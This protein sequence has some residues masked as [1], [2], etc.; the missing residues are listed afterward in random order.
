MRGSQLSV[1][2]SQLVKYFLFFAFLALTPNL[3]A[4]STPDRL[5]TFKSVGDAEL[6]LH[7]FNPKGHKAGDKRPVIVFFFGGGWVGGTPA[8]F[9]QQARS[10]ADQGIVAI[11]AEYRVKSR[12]KTS[13]FECVKDGKSAI[14]WVRHHSEEL[15]IDPNRI[16]ASGGS[17][18]GHVAACTALILGHEEDG[19]D[20]SVSAF[21]NALILFNPVI[22]TTEKG[23]GVT[24]V[25]TNRKNEIS[26]CHHVREGLP[27][28]LIFHGTADKTVPIENVRQ[29]SMLMNEAGNQCTLVEFDHKIHGFFN[30]SWFRP[31]SDDLDFH[32]TMLKSSAFLAE[33]GFL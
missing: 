17:A 26:P 24:A 27:P 3:A 22:D 21:P 30:G 4:Q 8:Q 15:G 20:S 23:F 33:L 7:V 12:H 28:T 9:Y 10:F 31:E 11:S 19:E 25:G 29:F 5:L 1:M 18:G 2:K 13:P 6:Q 16:V 32:A 14:R